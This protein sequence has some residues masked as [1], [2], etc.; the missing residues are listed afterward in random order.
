MR[1]T[2]KEEKRYI[3]TMICKVIGHK[4]WYIF[5]SVPYCMRCEYIPSVFDRNEYEKCEKELQEVFLT[6]K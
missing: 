2:F 5:P 4:W 6:L 1:I 3:K